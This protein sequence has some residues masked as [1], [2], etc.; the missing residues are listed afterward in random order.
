[1]VWLL[2]WAYLFRTPSL[3]RTATEP[4]SY[5]EIAFRFRNGGSCLAYSPDGKIV[6]TGGQDQTVQLW[7]CR[8]GELLRTLS[9]PEPA[10]SLAFSPDGATLVCRSATSD[11]DDYTVPSQ[12]VLLWE[13]ASGKLL[14]QWGG[15]KDSNYQRYRIG[16]VACSPSGKIV[17]IGASSE[18]VQNRNG[19]LDLWDAHTGTLL[20]HLIVT[21]G[22]PGEVAFSPDGNTLA[23][24]CPNPEINGSP[25]IR[26]WDV[27]TGEQ[28][29]MLSGHGM[30]IGPLVFSPN[31]KMLAAGC[32]NRQNGNSPGTIL[33]WDMQTGTEAR[34][35][36]WNDTGV[37]TY[38]FSPD[39]KTLVS[40]HLDLRTVPNHWT[41]F[42]GDIVFWD[43]ATGKPERIIPG[44]GFLSAMKYSPDGS[45][46]ATSDKNIISLWNPKTGALLRKT[47]CADEQYINSLAYSPDGK[48]LLGS[49]AST[50]WLDA[51]SLKIRAVID[52]GYGRLVPVGY[53]RDGS[54]LDSGGQNEIARW[55]LRT[56]RLQPQ[57]PRLPAGWCASAAFSPDHKMLATRIF[58][59]PFSAS[60]VLSLWDLQ[61]GESR[62]KIEEERP[63][64]PPASPAGGPKV[65]MPAHWNT[66]A[67]TPDGATVV[68][69]GSATKDGKAGI[70]WWDVRSGALRRSSAED[71]DEV[72]AIAISATG[73]LMA[74]SG[75]QETA[76]WDA[77][78]DKQIW[79]RSTLFPGGAPAE[80]W[81]AGQIRTLAFSPDG[82]TLA[83]G[84]TG[85]VRLWDVATGNE[86]TQMEGHARPITAVA[87]SPDGTLLASAS[88]D[89]TVRLWDMSTREIRRVLTQDSP[90]TA[91]TFSTD[92]RLLI[93]ASRDGK[94][95]LWNPETGKL[96]LTMQAFLRHGSRS[97]LTWIA[98]TP[99]GYFDGSPDIK[100]FVRWRV[101]DRFLPYASFSRQRHR[102]DRVQAALQ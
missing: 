96:L 30:D 38:A 18:D 76:L 66:M 24:T 28:R 87:F 62:H 7:D 13:T 70:A 26:L 83:S 22:Y 5:P 94:S 58:D 25:A 40:K 91:V 84:D 71:A 74:T 27:Q 32:S 10:T 51:R 44:H 17:A 49:G 48:T 2:L 88:E 72:F 85:R 54:F 19:S 20:H 69:G 63:V 37:S 89:G 55:D 95:R 9:I 1:M 61:T 21:D 86:I 65:I 93:T 39:G 14:K 73:K 92:G 56:G 33:V 77:V 4:S 8:N 101:G 60:A 11:W 75:R 45:T 97:P 68:L 6:A 81:R 15:E 29:H 34:K 102:P 35:L 64:F 90:L 46:L 12:H 23:G 59:R 82:R 57:L 3:P 80:T 43:V 36:T 31:G 78:A 99:E 98:Y 52:S 67:F 41:K 79:K 100:E 53:A 42:S 47:V 50:R 16:V